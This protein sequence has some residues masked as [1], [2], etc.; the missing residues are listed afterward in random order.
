MT[1][2]IPSRRGFLTGLVATLATPA[3]VRAAS[4]MPVAAPRLIS[5]GDICTL[6]SGGRNLLTID[7]ITREAV[8]LFRNSNEFLRNIDSQYDAAFAAD[9]CKI[10]STLHIRLPSDF[11]ISDRPMDLHVPK[12]S[13]L[14]WDRANAPS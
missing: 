11:G 10:G 7:M 6:Q 5:V 1:L 8:R 12:S 13:Y 9:N 3:V 14:E 4:L 2:L